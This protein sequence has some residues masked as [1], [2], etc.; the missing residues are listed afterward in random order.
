M[1][2]GVITEAPGAAGEDDVSDKPFFVRELPPLNQA[3]LDGLLEV[4]RQR[5]EALAVVDEQVEKTFA[6]LV[7]QRLQKIARVSGD[8]VAAEAGKEVMV[9][10]GCEGI[11]H[12]FVYLFIRPK[13]NYVAKWRYYAKK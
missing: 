7:L 13:G 6:A 4:T 1:F 5:A 2:D 3:E 10:A 12:R 8:P 11:G 9:D